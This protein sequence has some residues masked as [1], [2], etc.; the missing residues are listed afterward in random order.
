MKWDLITFWGRGITAA[1]WK[2][3]IHVFLSFVSGAVLVLDCW[4]V[5]GYRVRLK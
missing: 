3:H 2:R 5:P 1:A 4:V